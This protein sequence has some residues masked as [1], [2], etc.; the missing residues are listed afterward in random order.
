[1]LLTMNRVLPAA[2]LHQVIRVMMGLPRH[3]AIKSH[4]SD[5]N[6]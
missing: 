4:E 1:M 2:G 3:G 5:D 6:G